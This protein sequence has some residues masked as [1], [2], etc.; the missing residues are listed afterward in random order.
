[1]TTFAFS[2]LPLPVFDFIGIMA[3]VLDYPI[4]KFAAATLLGRIIRNFIIAWT[5]AK[6]L[7]A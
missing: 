2:T 3:G 5:G 1:M 7:P 6:I 4:W